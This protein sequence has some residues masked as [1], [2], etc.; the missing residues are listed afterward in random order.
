[1]EVGR[2]AP[3]ESFGWGGYSDDLWRRLTAAGCRMGCS[4][5]GVLGSEARWGELMKSALGIAGREKG[6]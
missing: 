3:L 4:L 2:E 5:G 6:D 1:M